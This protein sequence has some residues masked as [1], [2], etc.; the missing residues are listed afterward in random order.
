MSF[1]RARPVA[2][3]DFYGPV[4]KG[5][6]LAQSQMLTRL[7]ACSGE[8]PE[9][10]ADLLGDLVSLLHMAEHHLENEDR[11]VHTALEARAPGAALRLAQ[12]H[13][14]HRETFEALEALIGQAETAP[15]AARPSV[16]RQLYLR[17]SLHVA[18]DLTHMAEE[19]QLLLPILQSLFTDAELQGVE[20]RILSDL[21]AHEV[22]AFGRFMI[23][24]ATQGE[25]IAMLSAMRATAPAEAFEAILTQ[26]ARP[27][28]SPADYAHLC[29]GL[30]VEPP[31]VAPA[32]GE[33]R[34]GRIPS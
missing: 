12:G 17:F 25:R 4:H 32:K 3:F 22:I 33:L 14:Q 28:L 26:A 18:E 21:T 9:A 31:W 6:R 8:D 13:A 5:L 27:A 30:G 1:L 19:E 34:W 2:T 24:A 11:W 23:P 16:L 15:A 7:G 20:D 10:L 29:R